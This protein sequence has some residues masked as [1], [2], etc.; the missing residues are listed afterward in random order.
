M[1]FQVK[2]SFPGLPDA[3]GVGRDGFEFTSPGFFKNPTTAE[4]LRHMAEVIHGD[5]AAT[6][7]ARYTLQ[8]AAKELEDWEWLR[9]HHHD[10]DAPILV[11]YNSEKYET[12]ES[13]I[14]AA[15]E[16]GKRGATVPE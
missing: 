14:D 12:L 8:K 4:T 9:K 1:T 10:I 6:T 3:K 16:A 15:R 11:C 5:D 7:V 2:A 13:A